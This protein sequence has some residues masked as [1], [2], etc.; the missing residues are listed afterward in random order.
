MCLDYPQY[1]YPTPF[2]ST[3]YCPFLLCIFFFFLWP[4]ESNYCSLNSQG[5]GSATKH[6]QPSNSHTPPR[7]TLI[8]SLPLAAVNCSAK[9]GTSWDSSASMLTWWLAYYCVDSH[10]CTGFVSVMPRPCPSDRISQPPAGP[11]VLR[12]FPPLLW[13]PL[14]LRLLIQLSHLG[15]SAHNYWFLTL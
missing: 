12:F 7:K 6:G 8:T 9:G 4:T 3:P 1:D 14:S 15:L 11:L 5:F 13:Y 2:G 10:S